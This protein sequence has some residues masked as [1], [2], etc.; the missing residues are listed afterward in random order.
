MN[1]IQSCGRADNN[2]ELEE[3]DPQLKYKGFEERTK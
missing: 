1:I 2:G 3:S